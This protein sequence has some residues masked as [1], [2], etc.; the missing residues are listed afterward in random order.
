MS[1]YIKGMEMPSFGNETIIRIQSGGGILDQYGHY[2]NCEAVP[3]P[4]H[5][6]LGD[7]DAL[8]AVY[9]RQI[10]RHKEQA[11]K[12]AMKG[13]GYTNDMYII[14]RNRDIISAL[15]AAPTIIPAEDKGYI[16]APQEEYAGLKR[17]YVVLKSDTGEIVENC[18]VLRPDKDKAAIAALLAYADAADNQVLAKD[19]RAWLSTISAE[20]DEA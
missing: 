11:E 8:I 18:F 2:L 9:E 3:V 13:T 15:K 5:G 12:A 6:R 17:K 7:L 14:D 4:A 20:G 10:E 1:I 16:L 19:I